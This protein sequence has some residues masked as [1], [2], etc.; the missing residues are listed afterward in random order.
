MKSMK[1]YF[2][3]TRNHKQKGMTLLET[4]VVLAIFS[5][6]IGLVAVGYS[7]WKKSQGTSE[8]RYIS[9]TLG[10]AIQS[11]N[12]PNFAATTLA[13]LVNKDCFGD[14]SNVLGKGTA[15]A[16]ANSKLANA[17]YVVAPVGL[18]GGT[19]NGI[20]VTTGPV[21]KRSCAGLV[22]ALDDGASRIVVTPTGGTAVTVKP[23]NGALN[24]DAMG[25]ACN[26][27]N[28]ASIASAAGRS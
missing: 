5:A 2:P 25:L 20:Q 28:T 13:T 19:N 26:S 7:V 1:N 3:Q 15:T 23:D 10:C 17:V 8:G 27:A 4:L 6:F 12:A 14:G 11:I 18:S 22:A 21:S 16:T 24:D 9:F